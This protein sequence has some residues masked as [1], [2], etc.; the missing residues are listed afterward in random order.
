[1]DEDERGAGLDN[2]A[3][4]PGRQPVFTEEEENRFV[5]HAIALSSFGFPI[6]TFDLRCGKRVPGKNGEKSACI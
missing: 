6:T 5:A 1:M 2:P 4:I 3:K